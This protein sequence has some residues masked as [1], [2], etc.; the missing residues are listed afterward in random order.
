MMGAQCLG[1]YGGALYVALI[2]WSIYPMEPSGSSS[3]TQGSNVFPAM[4]QE[5]IG[6]FIFVLFFKIVT[7]ER[8]YFSKENAINCF[9]IASA[10][11]ASRSIVN[12]AT[13]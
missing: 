7:D 3:G 5:I 2:N 10:Y 13:T 1:A 4:M 6:T 11:V 12:G 9:I 8:L